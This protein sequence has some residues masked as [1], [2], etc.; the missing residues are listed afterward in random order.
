MGN[1]FLVS[2]RVSSGVPCNSTCICTSFYRRWHRLEICHRLIQ[3]SHLRPS[4]LCSPP[5]WRDI[6]PHRSS[7]YV[8]I[9]VGQ[10]ANTLSP[11]TLTLLCWVYRFWCSLSVFGV[12]V[13][14]LITGWSKIMK[15]QDRGVYHLKLYRIIFLSLRMYFSWIPTYIRLQIWNS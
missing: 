5:R 9:L 2:I 14:G 7:W 13:H 3:D 6:R 11:Y 1:H 10:H 8:S 15:M 12:W 4:L